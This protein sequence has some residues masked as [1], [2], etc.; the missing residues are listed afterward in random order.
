MNT[1]TIKQ[2]L[3]AATVLTCSLSSSTAQDCTFSLLT[4]T[5][6]PHVAAIKDEPQSKGEK[7]N[8]KEAGHFQWNFNH[9]LK[10]LVPKLS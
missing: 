5:E 1:N 6:K 2:S 4:A 10:L 9:L 8:K 7:R 3:L